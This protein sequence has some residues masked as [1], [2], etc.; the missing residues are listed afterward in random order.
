[1]WPEPVNPTL[2]WGHLWAALHHCA[3]LR[4]SPYSLHLSNTSTFP[5]AAT[6]PHQNHQ[7]LF[8]VS[9]YCP[10]TG[11][12]KLTSTPF[13]LL[14]S[15]HRPCQTHQHPFHTTA[16]SP[17][18]SFTNAPFPL[19]PSYQPCQTHQHPF[20]TTALSLALSEL[21]T[22]LLQNHQLLLWCA[23]S[24]VLSDSPMLISCYCPVTSPVRLANNPFILLSSY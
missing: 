14:P 17:A 1:M 3:A 16:Q 7:H 11:P 22:P 8:Q 23:Q 5:G 18:L 24:P 15:H 10:A 4:S 2:T 21:P 13:M 9:Y 6:L 19:L 12:V 20:H